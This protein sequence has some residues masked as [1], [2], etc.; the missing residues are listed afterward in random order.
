[1]EQP[2]ASLHTT[3]SS[4]NKLQI[5]GTWEQLKGRL[6]QTYGTLTDDD[7]VYVE[8]KEEELVGQLKAKLGQSEEEIRKL[9]QS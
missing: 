5:K 7:L 2:S 6:K 8:G 3:L 1:M 4:M 9:L